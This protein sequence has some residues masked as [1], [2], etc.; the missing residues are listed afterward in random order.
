MQVHIHLYYEVFADRDS[1]DGL[2]PNASSTSELYVQVFVWLFGHRNSTKSLSFVVLHRK[3]S[4]K[5]NSI[6][7]TNIEFFG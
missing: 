3:K 4:K 6:L 1:E 5:E 7:T 2:D